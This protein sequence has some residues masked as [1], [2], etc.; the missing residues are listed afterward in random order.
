MRHLRSQ[1]VDCS[2]Q[3]REIAISSLLQLRHRLLQCL[4]LF[5]QLGKLHWNVFRSHFN[6]TQNARVL[7]ISARVKIRGPQ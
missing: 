7:E 2:S 1:R 4:V 6:Y 5:A 3:H